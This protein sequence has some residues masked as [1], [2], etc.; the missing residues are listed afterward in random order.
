MIFINVY[1]AT[2]LIFTSGLFS[3]KTVTSESMSHAAKRTFYASFLHV[4]QDVLAYT[5]IGCFALH[6]ETCTLSLTLYPRCNIGMV[7]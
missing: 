1:L 7:S 4:W 2:V 6:A 3:P 5:V